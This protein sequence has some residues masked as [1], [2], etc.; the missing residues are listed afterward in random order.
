MRKTRINCPW[1]KMPFCGWRHRI[2]AIFVV[3]LIT[4]GI[5]IGTLQD[6]FYFADTVDYSLAAVNLLTDG[7]LGEAYRRAPLYPLF[8]AS[9][10]A[11]F[12]QTIAA[13]R[14][15]EAFMGACVAIAIATMGK[16]IGGEKVGA[17]AGLLWAI[18]PLAVFIA[19]LLYPTSLATTLL[20]WA[21]LCLVP[22]APQALAPRR[23]VLAGLLLGLAAL[24]VSVALVT[25]LALAPWISYWQPTRRLLFAGLLL[26]GVML[27]VGPWTL[28]NLYVYQHLVLVE[29]RL[30]EQLPSL[31]RAP[32]HTMGRQK[33]DKLSSILQKPGAFAQHFLKEFSYFW[34]L[35][36]RRVQ[37]NRASV[38]EKLHED[39]PRIVKETVFGTSW[40]SIVSALSVGPTFLFAL[41]GSGAMWCQKGRRRYLSLLCITILSFAITY[42]CFWGKTR[43]RIPIEPCLIVLSA[44]GLCQTW[45]ALAQR[46]TSGAVLNAQRT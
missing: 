26:L 46:R 36:P 19:G 40:T 5:F 14:A 21:L 39:H 23:V 4:R 25:S 11:L 37:M 45:L 3:G 28:R 29:P 17:L 43:Y 10:Y 8:L 41:I 35:Y 42:S 15:V 32:Q 2:A 30:V 6:G 33:E 12:G 44:Y 18:Y 24:T 27:P 16:R 22:E 31:G 9:I 7:E 13:V 20:V 1:S 34:E 38:R